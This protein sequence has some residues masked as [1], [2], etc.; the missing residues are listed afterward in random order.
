[1]KS[2]TGTRDMYAILSNS[3]VQPTSK[4]KLLT[5]FEFTEND[6]KQIDKFPFKTTKNCKFQWLQYRINH[7]RLITNTF[8]YKIKIKQNPLCSFCKKEK[9]NMIN[10]LWECENVQI[11][12]EAFDNWTLKYDNF[13]LNHNKKTFTLGYHKRKNSLK[14]NYILLTIK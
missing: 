12:L 4:Q 6:I 14:S 8:L 1:M 2:K 9:E 5:M 7:F 11:L 13:T 3:H 10:L